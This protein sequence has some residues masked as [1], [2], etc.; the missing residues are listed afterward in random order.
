[1]CIQ[2]Q[3]D[4]RENSIIATGKITIPGNQHNEICEETM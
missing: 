2:T 3:P 4:R 1:M